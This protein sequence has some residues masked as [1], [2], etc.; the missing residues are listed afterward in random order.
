MRLEADGRIGFSW[1][2]RW[3]VRRRARGADGWC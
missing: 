3:Q 1:S 2:L